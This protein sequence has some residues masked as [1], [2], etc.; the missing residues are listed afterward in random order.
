MTQKYIVP[1]QRMVLSSVVCA[2]GR[3]RERAAAAE[4]VM[5]EMMVIMKTMLSKA[6]ARER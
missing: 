4:S 5:V 6:M 3:E 1:S 2:F